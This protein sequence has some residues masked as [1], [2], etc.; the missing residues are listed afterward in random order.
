MIKYGGKKRFTVLTLLLVM[1]L[2]VAAC[3]GGGNS[4]NSNKN[5]SGN[6]ANNNGGSGVS[7]DPYGKYEEEITVEMGRTTA[8]NPKLPKG[9]TYEN[10]AYTRYVKD[11]L[12]VV[13]KNAFESNGDDYNRQV[14]LAIASGELPDMMRVDTKQELKEL[15]DNDLIADLTDVYDKFAT[16]HIKSIYNSYDGRALENATID[17]RL[18]ALPT[19]AVD[20]APTMVWLRQDWIDDLGLTVDEDKDK[21]ISV[22]EIENL[23]KQFIENDPGKS[24]N[25]IGIPFVNTLNATDYGASAFTMSGVASVFNAFP[26]YWI[27]EEGKVVYGS[28]TETTK[29]S[30][31]LMADWFKKGIVDP[32]FGT[33]TWDDIMALVVN[34]QT[35]IVFGPWHMP[36]W[37]LMTVKQSDPKTNFVAYTLGDE[38]GKVNVIHANPSSQF[39]V[40]KKDYKHP[41]IAVKILNLFFDKIVNDKNLAENAPEVAKY[42]EDAVDNSAR[43]INIEVH[44]ATSLLEDYSDI[45]RAITDEIK[46]EEVRTAE[47]RY[48]VLSIKSYLEE[49]D[50]SNVTGWARYASRMEGIGLIHTV[51]ENNQFH[52]TTPVFSDTTMTMQQA[53]ANLQKMEQE[54]FMK[55]VT[56]VSP[57]SE[58]DKF[59]EDWH[60]QGGT[61]ILKE[62]EAE[63]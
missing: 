13:V 35:G 23:A 9:D 3:S 18:M 5:A 28:T 40:V 21:V 48:N 42:Q 30:L 56:G 44:S 50:G 7:N 11:E 43:P 46:L 24:G 34:N 27:E 55:I 38:N 22:Q 41:E 29:Q 53:W 59:V 62:I 63:R 47:S 32:Q 39:M 2:L 17:G 31:E 6:T 37:G 60:K 49:Q 25:N 19:T 51:T 26:Q 52:W 15:V 61:Q 8:K 36:D 20:A 33:R 12:N 16:P 58:F 14:A 1:T 4:G 57:I 45:S 10:N 54:T